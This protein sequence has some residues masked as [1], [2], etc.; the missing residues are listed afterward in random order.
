[1]G[2]VVENVQPNVG[3]GVEDGW[4]TIAGMFVPKLISIASAL[5]LTGA[6][7]AQAAPQTPQVKVNYL[8][9][10]TPAEADQKE[11]TGALSKV[12][13]RPQFATD[14]EVAR[15]RSTM[16]ASSIIAG[17]GA[18]MQDEKPAASRWVRIRREYPASSVFSNA[19]YSFS[20][21]E[22]RVSETLVFRVRDPKDLL[23]I[24]LSTSVNAPMDPAQ[25][26]GTDTPPDR[27]RIERFGKSSIVLARC[28]DADQSSYEPLF[29]IAA[30]LFSAYRKALDTAKIVPVDYTKTAAVAPA[31]TKPTVDGNKK[32]K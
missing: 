21:S 32:R 6:C 1:L 14:F 12:P 24:S 13:A 18:Q 25:A 2:A 20:T 5:M 10:C 30:D 9:V 3:I 16:D 8:N 11:I 4:F 26:A 29:K 17:A 27:I 22:G 31:S 7:L 23:Q 28:K 19:Q 15:G